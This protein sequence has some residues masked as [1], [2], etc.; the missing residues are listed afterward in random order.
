MCIRDSGNKHQVGFLARVSGRMAIDGY[1][2]YYRNHEHHSHM[3][4][5]YGAF[6]TYNDELVQFTEQIQVLHIM[7]QEHTMAHIMITKEIIIYLQSKQVTIQMGGNL[8]KELFTMVV[9]L[10]I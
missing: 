1:A 4:Q 6:K 7:I 9:V 3:D 2:C 5:H 10:N 8:N